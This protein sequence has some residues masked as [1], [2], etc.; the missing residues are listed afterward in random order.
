MPSISI[1][2][3]WAVVTVNYIRKSG[4]E[5]TI[6][7]TNGGPNDIEVAN[8]YSDVWQNISRVIGQIALLKLSICMQR[9]SISKDWKIVQGD[10]KS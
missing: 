7:A 8:L 4:N 6:C 10:R 3:I 9:F 2:N 5:F 1:Q